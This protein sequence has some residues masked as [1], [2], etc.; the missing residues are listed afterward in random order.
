[1]SLTCIDGKHFIRGS[2]C[3]KQAGIVGVV[4]CLV[5]CCSARGGE[6]F[7]FRCHLCM[8]AVSLVFHCESIGGGLGGGCLRCLVRAVTG[9][10]RE[11]W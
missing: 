1:M 3:L 8:I 10:N 4:P 11:G 7:N 9:K 2:V 5:I 6:W